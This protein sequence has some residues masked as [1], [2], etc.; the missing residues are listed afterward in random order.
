[1]RN[2]MEDSTRGS[3]P[4]W[5]TVA[6]SIVLHVVLI[7]VKSFER[8]HPHFASTP[9]PI[10]LTDVPPTYQNPPPQSQPRQKEKAQPKVKKKEMQMA[11]SAEAPNNQI[12]PNAKFLGARNQKAEQEMKAKQIDDFRNGEGSGAKGIS[13]SAEEFMPP[14]A[15][16]GATKDDANPNLDDMGITSSEPAAKTGVKRNWK[17]LSL[18]D[19]GVGG[20]GSIASA[21]D[22][23]I[24][25]VANGDR[26]ILSTREFRYFSYYHRIKELLRQYWKP[27]VENKLYRMWAR[28][29]AVNKDELTTSLLVLLD[30]Q[31]KIQ[32]I[33]RMT[34]SG[35][36]DLDQAAIDS[37]QKAG[38]F[39]NPPKGIV[40]DDGFVRIK[41]DFVL[42]TESAPRINF[43]SAGSRGGGRDGVDR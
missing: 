5:S 27:M 39:P 13:K 40:E 3:V 1:M 31:G 19:L 29:D 7:T 12:D 17:T 34:S 18:K 37:F 20:D 4:F 8:D 42:K 24:D 33:S 22:D 30:E 15:Q 43:Q 2:Y 41:W 35:F 9:D 14:T 23:K 38:P 16:D 32:K 6:I 25:G 26:T 11:E 36:A 28:G 21:T 10:E